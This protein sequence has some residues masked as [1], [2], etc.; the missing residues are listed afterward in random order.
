MSIAYYPPD[1]ITV[2]GA[3]SLNCVDGLDCAALEIEWF[4]GRSF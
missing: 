3:Q 1:Q 4:D 2:E